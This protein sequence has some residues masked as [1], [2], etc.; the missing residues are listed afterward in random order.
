MTTA[1]SPSI[2]NVEQE[3]LDQAAYKLA[4]LEKLD[5]SGVG[6]WNWFTLRT[7][8][9]SGAGFFT[10]SYDIFVIN[11]VTPMLG[12]VYYSSSNNKMPS[13]IEGVLKGM[14]SV[15][16]MF[17]QLIFGFCGDIFGRKI[18]GLELLIIIIGTINCATSASAVRGVSVIGFLSFWRFILG[19]GIGGDYP[20]SATITS[21]WSSTGRRGMM[22]ALIFSMQGIGNLAASI[23]T[24]IVLACFKTAINA[25]VM[26]LDYVWR[27]CIGLG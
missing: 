11:L 1:N 24:L 2:Y 18:Y 4:S 3:Q 7:L 6:Y 9:T 26:N 23:V 27:L 19:I 21:E 13:N 16:T 8:L 20:M 25:D 14:S 5:K 17:G 15:G 10:D 12:Y 22:M